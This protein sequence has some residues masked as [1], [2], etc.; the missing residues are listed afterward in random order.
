MAEDR[1]KQLEQQRAAIERKIRQERQRIKSEQRK[2]ETR[3]KIILG[4]LIEAHCELHPET[5]FAREVDRL[6]GK[7]V[8][9]DRERELFGLSPLPAASQEAG[10]APGSDTGGAGLSGLF[11]R[12]GEEG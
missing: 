5:E 4:G 11:R 7:F 12:D 10:A 2:R 9:G 6:V 1:L 3:R 8:K